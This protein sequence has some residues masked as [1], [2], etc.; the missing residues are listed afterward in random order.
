MK[1]LHV[2]SIL[3]SLLSMVVVFSIGFSTWTLTQ[4][5][6]RTATFSAYNVVDSGDNVTM[7]GIKMFEY[8]S[9][10]FWNDGQTAP[11]DT[12]KISATYAIDVDKCKKNATDAGKTWNGEVTVQLSLW[13]ENITDESYNLFANVNNSSNKKNVSVSVVKNSS[14][15]SFANTVVSTPTVTNSGKRLDVVFTITGLPKGNSI[16]SFSFTVDYIFEVPQSV[17]G[18]SEGNFRQMFGQYLKTKNVADQLPTKFHLSSIVENKY[19]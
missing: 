13:Y 11:S 14:S 5:E 19:N 12:G 16:G 2:I 15:T 1:K 6:T 18:G 7:T 4:V 17:S 10:Y 9:F 3:M 8:S